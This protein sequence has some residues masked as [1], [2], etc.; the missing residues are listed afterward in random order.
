MLLALNPVI[1]PV[2]SPTG[3]RRAPNQCAI[4]MRCFQ[5]TNSAVGPDDLLFGSPAIFGRRSTPI[6]VQVVSEH[7]ICHHQ[8]RVCT[9]VIDPSFGD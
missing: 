6:E 8:G 3:K 1:S 7:F 2:S 5:R 9:M 4:G